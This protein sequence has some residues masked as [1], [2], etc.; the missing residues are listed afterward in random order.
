MYV[1]YNVI[2]SVSMLLMICVNSQCPNK[3]IINHDHAIYY[4]D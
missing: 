3:D 1:D 4:Y 2:V